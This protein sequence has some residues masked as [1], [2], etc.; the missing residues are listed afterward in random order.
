MAEM[1]P[2]PYFS[3]SERLMWWFNFDGGEGDNDED[4]FSYVHPLERGAEAVYE[5]RSGDSATIRLPG[6]KEIVLQEVVVRAREAS[7]DL[8]VGSLWFESGGQLVRAAFRPAAPMDM[9]KVVG[10]DSFEDV[11]APVRATLLTPFSFDV[12]A[13][14]IDYG[15]YGERWWLPRSQTARGELRMGFVRS[16]ATLD[17]SFRYA[18]VN[19]TDTLPTVTAGCA[20]SPRISAMMSDRWLRASWTVWCPAISSSAGVERSIA[21]RATRSTIANGAVTFA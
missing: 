18:S 14:T 19:G 15:L 4:A 16:T 11:P 5:Y 3:G 20:G 7:E 6:G 2:I 9:M 13:F 1:V 12:E 17:Q 10:E 21:R 8:I